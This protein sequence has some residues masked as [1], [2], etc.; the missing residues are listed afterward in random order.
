MLRFVIIFSF[1]LNILMGSF[2]LILIYSKGGVS[3]L[4]EKLNPSASNED[5]SYS[6]FYYRKNSI[7]KI[8]PASKKGVV[9]LGDSIIEGCDWNELFGDTRIRNRGIGGD[10]TEGILLRLDDIIQLAPEKIFI[11]IGGNDLYRKRKKNT[12]DNI[13]NISLKYEEIVKRTIEKLPN[14]V[15]YILS[16][17]PVNHQLGYATVTD[18]EIRQ[19]NTSLEGLAMKYRMTYIDLYSR[20]KTN[21]NQ[22]N[23]EYTDDGLHLNGKGYLVFKTAIQK[24]VGNVSM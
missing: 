23:P 17:I 24:Y 10:W 11:M 16:V 7:F 4:K 21:D 9:F 13:K 2:I 18:A 12:T 19:L 5:T 22:L 1:F 8:M 6:R 15:L 3:Y 14:T 20:L